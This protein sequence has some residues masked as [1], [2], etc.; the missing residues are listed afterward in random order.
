MPNHFSGL[1]RF[2]VALVFSLVP[3]GSGFVS[4]SGSEVVCVSSLSDAAGASSSVVD[5]EARLDALLS[6]ASSF[7]SDVSGV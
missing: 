7:W 3:S 4:W 2:S 5:E 6:F 1:V